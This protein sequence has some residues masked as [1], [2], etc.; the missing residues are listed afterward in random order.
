MVNHAEIM[1][2]RGS[3]IHICAL[4]VLFSVIIFAVLPRQDNAVFVVVD[5]ILI[6]HA[7]QQEWKRHSCREGGSACSSVPFIH[8]TGHVSTVTGETVV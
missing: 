2:Y 5:D 1:C 4:L 8:Y 7:E 3:I 6:P